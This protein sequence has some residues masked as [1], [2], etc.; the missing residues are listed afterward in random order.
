MTTLTVNLV[1]N[2]TDY[3]AAIVT[4]LMTYNITLLTKHFIVLVLEFI[5]SLAKQEF[6][7]LEL[8]LHFCNPINNTPPST[9]ELSKNANL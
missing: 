5:H 4:V 7:L 3:N 2:S 1:S 9:S 6:I 8:A